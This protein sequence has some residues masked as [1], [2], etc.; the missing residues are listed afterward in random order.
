MVITTSYNRNIEKQNSSH[1]MIPD[2]GS[3]DKIKLLAQ[4]KDGEKVISLTDRTTGDKYI[5]SDNLDGYVGG[6]V[7]IGFKA[8]FKFENN[9]VGADVPIGEYLLE[10][11]DIPDGFYIANAFAIVKTAFAGASGTLAF[12]VEGET[13]TFLKTATA[14]TSFSANAIVPLIPTHDPSTWL[15]V[16]NGGG[17]IKMNIAT[18]AQTAGDLIVFGDLINVN[19]S[20]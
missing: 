6:L 7:K 12:G 15:K 3:T 8:E 11:I 20:N 13:D 18:T 16:T 2:I 10:G 17:R 5:A 14:I 4:A 1:Y 19:Y 9:A